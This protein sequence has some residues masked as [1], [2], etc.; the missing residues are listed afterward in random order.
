MPV[1]SNKDVKDA[2]ATYERRHTPRFKKF[3]IFRKKVED[4]VYTTTRLRKSI[5]SD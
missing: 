5:S 4:V 3:Q 2:L 1:F